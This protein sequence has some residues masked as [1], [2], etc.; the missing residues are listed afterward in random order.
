MEGWERDFLDLSC[1]LVGRSIDEDSVFAE[2]C[3]LCI[4]D[5]KNDRSGS[6]GS[7]VDTSPAQFNMIPNETN[8]HTHTTTLSTHTAAHTQTPM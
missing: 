2:C 4:G 7:S 1:G 3:M 6:R 8:E 5:A